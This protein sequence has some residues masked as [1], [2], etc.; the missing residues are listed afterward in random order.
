MDNLK[1][2][3]YL[4]KA[5]H[6]H[7]SKYDYSLIKEYKGVMFK[8]PVKCLEH[9]VWEVS[10][11][12]HINKKSGCPLC[13]GFNLKNQDKIKIAQ[14]IH[15]NKYDYSEIKGRILQKEK[16]PIKCV[17]HGV[18]YQTWDNHVNKKQ[19]CPEC[20]EYGRKKRTIES[21]ITQTVGLNTDY[22]YYWDT[23]IDYYVPMD[24][25]C[26][27]HGVFKQT[28][29]NHLFGQRCPKC[30]RS[31]G[32]EK[33]EEILK[34]KKISYIT[35][36]TFKECINPKTKYMLRFDFYIPEKNILIEYDGEL[37]FK[38]VE[39]FGGEKT[40]KKYK[41]LDNIKTKYCLDNNIKLIRIPYFNYTEISNILENE[42]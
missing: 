34:S 28:I 21:I 14:N 10:L 31:M 29:A 2:K 5:K 7:S 6:I 35:Q 20:A 26:S 16:Q 11:D 40:L 30:I 42:I 3:K 25:E 18:F 24:I 38:S 41:Y 39:Y 27:K 15:L 13:K 33:I 22:K 23:Y 17:E 19:G 37:H 1:L 12:N 8:Y 36:K 32:E 9:G 4:Q